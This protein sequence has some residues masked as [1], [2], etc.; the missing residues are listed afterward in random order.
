MSVSPLCSSAPPAR[1]GKPLIILAWA[2]KRERCDFLFCAQKKARRW[3]KKSR[4]NK[5]LYVH[6]RWWGGGGVNKV[7]GSAGLWGCCACAFKGRVAVFSPLRSSLPTLGRAAFSPVNFTAFIWAHKR[8]PDLSALRPAGSSGSLELQRRS[9]TP[10][11]ALTIPSAGAGG[12]R[13]GHSSQRRY[14]YTL[15][16]GLG[17]SHL[18]RPSVPPA[19]G[20]ALCSADIHHTDIIVIQ[21]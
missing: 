11:R 21:R 15:P 6:V 1:S 7:D 20:P 2:G 12:R 4:K 14:S 5:Y 17:F 9:W 8:L 19:Q 18:L 10:H 3:G 16:G 13:S